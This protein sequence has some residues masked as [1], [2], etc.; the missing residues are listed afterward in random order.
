MIGGFFTRI[1]LRV[2]L[3]LWV[4]L[5]LGITQIVLGG[6]FLLYQQSAADEFFS[7]RVRIRYGDLLTRTTWIL[8]TVFFVLGL[9]LTIVSGRFV[10]CWLFD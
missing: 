3:T 7:R 6:I 8:G 5:L 4:M 9:L 10:W 1:S 2:R